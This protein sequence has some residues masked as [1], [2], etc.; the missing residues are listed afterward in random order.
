MRLPNKVTDRKGGKD[1]ETR[2]TLGSSA[3]ASKLAPDLI[4]KI[5]LAVTSPLI[6]LI[7]LGAIVLAV[8]AIGVGVS[9]VIS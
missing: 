6:K 5:S 3:E 4:G 9:L 7:P 2:I 1:L 8:S